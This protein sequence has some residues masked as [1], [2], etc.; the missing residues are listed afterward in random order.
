MH[1][2]FKL[3]DVIFI[4]MIV[5]Q[6]P[7]HQYGNIISK[8]LTVRITEGRIVIIDTVSNENKAVYEV[9][10][11]CFQSRGMRLLIE[12]NDLLGMLV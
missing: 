1:N 10:F 12:E 6:F 4:K 9:E 5:P 3:N 7:K 8:S 2:K 11:N